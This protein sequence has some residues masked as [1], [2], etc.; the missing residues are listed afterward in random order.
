MLLI[1]SKS[2]PDK[3]IFYTYLIQYG[4]EGG[5]EPIPAAIGQEAGCTLDRLPN[6][7]E[8]FNNHPNI[9]SKETTNYNV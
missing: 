6:T 7:T 3:T 4:V 2:Q 9:N 5:L 1:Y 8:K